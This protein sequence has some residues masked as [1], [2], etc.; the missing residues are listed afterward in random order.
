M[1]AVIPEHILSQCFDRCKE[2]EPVC[3][4]LNYYSDTKS[5]DLNNGTRTAHAS[6]MIKNPMAIYFE[7]HNRVSRG[8]QATVAASSCQEIYF[9]E[10][11]AKDG[12]YWLN[13]NGTEPLFLTFCKMKN[14]G[15][16]SDS[17]D[18]IFRDR[19][20]TN[21]AAIETSFPDLSAFTVCFWFKSLEQQLVF[22]SYARHSFTW[23]FMG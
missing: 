21:F 11:S 22:L 10:N 19:N 13:S 17:F 14:G 3:Q 8:S 20:T 9:K 15:D 23:Q 2:G 18:L 5:C 4:N 12:F 7:S 6:D 16:T 1:D